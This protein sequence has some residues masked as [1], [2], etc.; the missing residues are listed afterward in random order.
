MH[1][2]ALY[3]IH[4]SI[5]ALDA[6]L[7]EIGDVDA[8]VVGGDI[9]WGPFPRQTVDRLASIQVPVLTLR[10]NADR[11]V[12]AGQTSTGGWVDEVNDWCAAQLT[13][14]QRESLGALPATVTL[15]GEI[16]EVLF[17]HATPRSDEEL[18]TRETPDGV[19][20]EIF[21]D[22]RAS[23]VVCG[24]THVQFDRQ[25]DGHRL[26]NAGSVGLPYED[27]P[28]A[29]WLEIDDDNLELRRTEYDHEAAA[30][31]IRTSSG[32]PHAERFEELILNPGGAA[33]ATVH[34]ES[35]RMGGEKV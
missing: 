34:F 24:H 23:I 18:I 26:V 4:G 28:G 2:A 6:V 5:D 32:C 25:V 27:V 30:A 20:G 15:V 17:C 35:L 22:V 8:I 33:Q 21:N 9:A 11:E 7:K 14:E 1:V 31:R 12:A 16:G 19:L 29:Y 10:G 3:D 13:D